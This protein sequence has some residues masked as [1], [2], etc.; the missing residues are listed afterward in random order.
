[1]YHIFLIHSSADGHLAC[2]HVLAIVNSAS[3][4]IGVHVSFQIMFFFLDIYNP[5]SGITGKYGSSIFSFVRNLHTVLHNG[6]TNL[7]SHQ[8]WRRVPFS[9]HSL[10]HLLFV[11]FLIDGHSDLCEVISHSSFDLHFSNN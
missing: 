10:Q 11:D 8:Q 2:F 1:M 6:Y 5:R 3:V 7:K 4:N 9:A